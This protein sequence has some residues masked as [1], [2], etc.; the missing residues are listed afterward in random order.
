MLAQRVPYDFSI[1]AHRRL[2]VNAQRHVFVI[3]VHD[4][5][6]VFVR[7]MLLRK[8]KVLCLVLYQE[9]AREVHFQN[10]GREFIDGSDAERR[11]VRFQPIPKAGRLDW[12]LAA[13]IQ[14]ASNV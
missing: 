12:F 4:V 14:D 2:P 5:A 11:Q 9:V 3:R 1:I 7:D 6:H 13:L 10:I 8:W